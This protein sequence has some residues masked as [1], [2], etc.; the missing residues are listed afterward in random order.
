MS[1]NT[2][3][4]SSSSSQIILSSRARICLVVAWSTSLLASFLAV[5]NWGQSLDWQLHL[6]AYTIFPVLGLLAFSLMWS[7][8]IAALVRRRLGV[9]AGVLHRYFEVTSLLVLALIL[10]HPGLLILQRFIDGYGLPPKSYES[11]VAPGL[12]WVT[13]LGSVSLL[14]FLAFEFRRFFADRSWWKYVPMAG[15]A[16]M[17]AIV[18][19]GLRIGDQLQ[20]GWYR[21]V[22]YIYAVILIGILATNYFQRY[23]RPATQKAPN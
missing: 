19:H 3:V 11:Y 23:S 2:S 1:K 20:S 22:W 7:H 14:A 6:N 15:D 4:L 8:Y 18:Y 16:A 12:G 9:E 13:V 5:L 21:Y 17:L 10:L